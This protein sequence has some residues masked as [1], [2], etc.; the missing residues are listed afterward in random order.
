LIEDDFTNHCKLSHKYIGILYCFPTYAV[1]TAVLKPP[2]TVG[3]R[4]CNAG[5]SKKPR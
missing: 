2:S 3:N 4:K 5:T 1:Q